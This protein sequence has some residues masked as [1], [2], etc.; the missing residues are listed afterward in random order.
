LLID[1]ETLT[2]F[3][4]DSDTDA[5]IDSPLRRSFSICSLTLADNDKASDTDT[6]LL[7]DVDSLTDA[8]TEVLAD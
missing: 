4:T 8:D 3:E 7:I 6:A 1:S 2:A 5:E